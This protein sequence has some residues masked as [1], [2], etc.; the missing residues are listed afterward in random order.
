L[1]I[2]FFEDRSWKSEGLKQLQVE[3]SILKIKLLKKTSFVF[4]CFYLGGGKGA[5]VGK[6]SF[7]EMHS[8]RKRQDLAFDFY[9]I[10]FE[11]WDPTNLR[12]G[13][14]RSIFYNPKSR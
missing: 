4:C 9:L 5:Q 11:P 2:F 13:R 8:L 1:T 14:R 7:L 12:S 3:N 6:R 10:R